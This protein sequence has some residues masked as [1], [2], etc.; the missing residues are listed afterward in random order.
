MTV[1]LYY[2]QPLGTNSG[3]VYLTLLEKGVPFIGHHLS[4]R[5]FEHLKPEYL[6]INPR[7]Q[8]P[9]MVHDGVAL[10]EG[11][12]MNEYIDEAFEGPPLRP[13]NLIE[14][15]R[16]RVWCRWSENDLGRC[17]MMINWNRIMPTFI[18]ARDMKEVDEI[19]AKVPDPDRRRSWKSAFEQKTPPEMIE[20]SH[21]RTRE[22][23]KRIEAQLSKTPYFAGQ[24]Y[25]LADIDFLNF[26]GG[27][28]MMWMPD[29]VNEKATPAFWDWNQ[30]V[31]ARP[32][33]IKMREARTGMTTR[34]QMER[35][36]AGQSR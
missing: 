15:E 21:R 13:A 36:A 30:R 7:G 28:L 16:M 23:I 25:S 8:V 27:I 17:L 2:F 5:D 6:K 32:A 18:G 9:A 29:L 31:A 26:C 22:A 4:G 24:T 33:V 34:E 10:H 19:L 14:R 3:R 12:T 11:M 20:E 1:E 35:T